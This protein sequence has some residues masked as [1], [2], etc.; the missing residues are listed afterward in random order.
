MFSAEFM[1]KNIYYTEAAKYTPEDVMVM[2]DQLKEKGYKNIII[3]DDKNDEQFTE[4]EAK[5]SKAM[6]KA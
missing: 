6:E 2:V 1:D 3:F 4:V 5:I